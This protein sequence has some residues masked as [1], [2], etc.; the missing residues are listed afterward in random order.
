MKEIKKCNFC[1]SNKLRLW[2]VGRDNLHNNPGEF[3]LFKCKNCGLIFINPQPSMREIGKYYPSEYYSFQGIRI[4]EKYW[5]VRLK[6]FLYDLYFNRSNKNYFLKTVLSP[7]KALVRGVQFPIPNK[8]LDVGC[9]S[10]QFLYEMKI[11][12]AKEVHG[13]EPG[14]FNKESADEHRIKIKNSTLSEAKYDKNFFDLV[15]MN[16]V[17]EHVNDPDETLKEIQRTLRPG[18][19]LIIGVPNTRSLDCYLFGVN[20]YN[21]D[22]PRHLF[23]YSSKNLS[24]HLKSLGFK[25][26][27]IRYTSGRTYFFNS[28]IYALRHL[29]GRNFNIQ[30]NKI[31][32]GFLIIPSLIIGNILNFL[33]FGDQMEI[34]CTK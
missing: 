3:K 18:G 4:K 32:D 12:G 6:L 30:K 14:G 21:L 13:V 2:G 24:K 27:K 29:F 20:W 28:T 23:D 17:L 22:V 16:H 9:G 1:K 11:L 5:P 26:I 34:S 15:T 31:I 25:K 8:V 10:G 33:K 19:K 7:L